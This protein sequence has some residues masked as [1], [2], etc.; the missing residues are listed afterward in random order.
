MRNS[1]ELVLLIEVLDQQPLDKFYV[2][3]NGLP[4]SQFFAERQKWQHPYH[5]EI[6]FPKKPLTEIIVQVVFQFSSDIRFRL[7]DP[8]AKRPTECTLHL[9]GIIPSPIHTFPLTPIEPDQLS[10]EEYEQDNNFNVMPS[11]GDN[12]EHY[13]F[14]LK[15]F[16]EPDND[17]INVP[18]AEFYSG[19]SFH[20]DTACAESTDGGGLDEG[21]CAD[22][23]DGGYPIIQHPSTGT[24]FRPEEYEKN[25]KGMAGYLKVRV[26]GQ[27]N[28]TVE[29][30]Y[31]TDRKK[32]QV[33]GKLR[34]IGERGTVSYGRAEV[35]IPHR[36]KKG[37]VPRPV[38]W[39]L[40]FS[41]NPDKHMMVM[42]MEELADYVFFGQ[43]AHRIGTSDEHDAFIFIHGYNV[44]FEDSLLRAA[45]M[46]YDLHFQG[47]PI[48][49]S[50]PSKAATA[51]YL[52]DEDSIRYTVKN[53][54]Q[55]LRSVKSLN[56]AKKI[57]LV[58]HSMGNRALTDALLAL[59][60][61]GFFNGFLFNQIILAA[62]DID[63]QIFAEDIAPQ[64]SSVSHRMTLYTSSKDLALTTS[65]KLRG[66]EILRAGL[67]GEQI[68]ICKGIDT[69]DASQVSTD[70]LGHGYFASTAPLINDMYLLTRHNHSPKERNLNQVISEDA[71]YWEFSS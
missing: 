52:A 28:T 63:A 42:N 62:P 70:L 57:H 29:V 27:K 40:Q 38:W 1:S 7:D 68:L 41:E 31:A 56:N 51:G 67:S 33:K 17:D 36:K 13:H 8:G 71:I 9:G 14:S 48:V 11:I 15:S 6:S 50:W 43:V 35:N 61:E 2:T 32:T 46:A 53:F 4:L 16:R 39:K 30:F 19:G 47:A 21:S 26:I 44:S 65:R 64:L 5:V 3:I 59:H 54:V 24:G 22:N 10:D 60:Q 69:V 12:D 49:Y 23:D 34:Y 55:F 25:N 37:E 18:K 20:F 66:G 58:A 45:Q